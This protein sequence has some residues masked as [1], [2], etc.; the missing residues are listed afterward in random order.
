M[1]FHSLNSKV[2]HKYPIVGKYENYWPVRD[3]LKLHLKYKSAAN[4]ATEDKDTTKELS[5]VSP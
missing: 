5:K 1:V 3:I 2:A 4:K